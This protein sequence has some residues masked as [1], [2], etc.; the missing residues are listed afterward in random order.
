MARVELDA[1]GIDEV[2]TVLAGADLDR[3]ARRVLD[4]QV[5]ACPVDTGRLRGSLGIEKLV[6]D[7]G[8]PVRRIGS[9]VH[10]ALYVEHGTG[11]FG[12]HHHVIVPTV[13]QALYW[14]GAHHPVRS[15]KGQRAQPFIGPS[16]AAAAD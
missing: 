7:D 11:L 2:R 8:G 16:L 9:N 4:A 6:G 3:R 15:V 5:A 14:P 1:S 12:P 13:K 10:Y